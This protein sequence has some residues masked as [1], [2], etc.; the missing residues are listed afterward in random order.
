[1]KNKISIETIKSY[2]KYLMDEYLKINPQGFGSLYYHMVQFYEKGQIK[3]ILFI[4]NKQETKINIMEC[5]FRE[6]VLFFA[7]TQDINL[8]LYTFKEFLESKK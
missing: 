4:N 6:K 3:D 2:C 5:Y 1:M 7:K 8:K